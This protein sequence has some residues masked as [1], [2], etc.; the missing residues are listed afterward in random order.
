MSVEIT[1]SMSTSPTTYT[2]KFTTSSA[3]IMGIACSPNFGGVCNIKVKTKE[4]TKSYNGGCWKQYTK[5]QFVDLT[6]VKFRLGQRGCMCRVWAVPADGSG[7][8]RPAPC[9]D[10]EDEDQEEE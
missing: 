4:G 9:R 3:N 6:L 10:A 5:G 1:H 7:Y 2:R 8:Y